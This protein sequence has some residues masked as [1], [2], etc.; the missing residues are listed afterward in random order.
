M[1]AIPFACT[2]VGPTADEAFDDAVRKARSEHGNG[3]YSGSIAEKYSCVLVAAV[4]M[5]LADAASLGDR[6][7]GVDDER[8]SDK[9]GPAGAIELDTGGFYFFGW[10]SY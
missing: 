8:I 7:I 6:L 2:G 10:A 5:S 4:P 1:G 3:G 9:G